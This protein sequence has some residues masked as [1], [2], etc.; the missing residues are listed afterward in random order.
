MTVIGKKKIISSLVGQLPGCIGWLLVLSFLCIKTENGMTQSYNY[1]IAGQ[2]APNWTIEQWIDADGQPTD[3]IELADY[4]GKVLIL[5]GF[6]SWCPGC[7]SR[8]FPTLKKM[9]EAFQ[10]NDQIAF[11]AIQTVF[12]GH[13]TNTFKKLRASQKEYDLKIPFGHDSGAG[14]EESFS[15]LMQHYRT[16]GTPWFVL[17]NQEG[18]VLF[19]DFHLNADKAIEVLGKMVE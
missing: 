10:G 11:L 9:V 14:T 6:Q 8:G 2:Q 3:P 15:N 4:K 13:Q 5:F 12:E 1:G 18:K 7:H 19:N 17:I 16:G